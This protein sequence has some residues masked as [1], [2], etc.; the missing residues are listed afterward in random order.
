MFISKLVVMLIM[1]FLDVHF[2][3]G[4]HVN[5]ELFWKSHVIAHVKVG[6]HVN[7]EL[8]GSSFQSLLSS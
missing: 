7:Y 3:V 6:C 1:T 5:H 4:F 2:K 8:F